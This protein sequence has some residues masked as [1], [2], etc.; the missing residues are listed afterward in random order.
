MIPAPPAP[1]EAERLTELHALEVLDTP[2]EERF[3]RIVRLATR[4]FDV[5][6]AYVALVDADRQWFKARCGV[7]VDQTGRDISFCGHAILQDEPLIIPDASRDERF[8]DNPLVVGEP[9]IRFYAGY[10]LKGPKGY[11]VGT[12]CLA[13]RRPRS[14]DARQREIL[15]EL[16]AL[17]EHELQM[18]SLIYFQREL[19]ET[20]NALLASQARLARE[21]A[22]AAEYIQ[23]LLPARLDGP[24][25]TDWRF[26]S[27]S[28][29][30]GDLFGYHWLDDHQLAIYL[31][32]VCGH[33]VGA[34]LLSIAIHTALSGETLPNVRFDQ[35][36]E[37][38]TAL[39]LAFPME[40]HNHKF[41]TLWYGVYDRTR[42]TLR[43]A[44]GGHPPA[45]LFD[46][47]GSP[48]VQLG[49]PSPMIGVDPDSHYDT[50]C[51]T[52]TPGSRLYVFSD[53]VYEVSRGSGQTD[54]K[55]LGVNGLIPLLARAAAAEGS[56]VEQVLR[57]IQ[58][59]QGSPVFADDFSLL[60]IEFA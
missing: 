44:S 21:L 7:A 13:D 48:P 8:H 51:Q 2:S 55:A 40:R 50:H 52:V 37:V 42:R 59:F 26:L 5:P 27:S 15:G 29:L 45:L 54:G 18:V 24:V 57:E 19:L 47:N 30:G 14:L 6:I 20:K 3:D 23:S 53:G 56:R 12:F 17:A 4:I 46:A 38:L 36:G 10:P 16:A 28:Q 33:G 58:A 22:E 49:A 1:D 31:F 9:Y 60:E 34:S 35:P 25:R 43:Y 39:N 32:D 41:F 11:R